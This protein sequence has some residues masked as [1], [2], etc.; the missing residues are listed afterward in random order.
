MEKLYTF[1]LTM[2]LSTGLFAQGEWTVPQ[3]NVGL[4]TKITATW[5]GPCGTW[6]WDAMSDLLTNYGDENIVISLYAPSSSKLYN[7]AAEEIANE[8]G[9]GGT[10]NFAGNGLDQGTA[11]AQAESIVDT[12]GSAPVIAVPAYALDMVLADTIIIQTKTKF[13]EGVNGNFHLKVFV[14]EDKVVEE[15]NGQTGDVEHKMVVRKWFT[16]MDSNNV[17]LE[18]PASAGEVIEK[19]YM[20]EVD[21]E[22]DWDNLYFITTLWMEN[23]ADPNDLWYIN[24]QKMWQEGELKVG[25]GT[26]APIIYPPGTW[27]VGFGEVEAL[28]FQVYPNPAQSEL[29]IRLSSAQDFEVSLIDLLGKQVYADQFSADDFQ[30]INVS[31]LP[32]GVYMMKIATA[33]QQHFERVVI[34]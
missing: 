7:S 24:G 9:F 33:N 8:I 17:I 34:K 3:E 4:L 32:D 23:P 1:L 21:E 15:Q 2:G 11:V 22:W 16:A 30:S 10:P 28:D 25:Y 19:N 12:F 14:V 31:N 18:G 26:D 6:G 13:F 27:P 5:C 29:N 20:V